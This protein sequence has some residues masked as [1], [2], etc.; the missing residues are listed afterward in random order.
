MRI[1]LLQSVLEALVTWNDGSYDSRYDPIREQPRMTT[2]AKRK[3]R[4]GVEDR[5]TRTLHLSDGTTKTEPSSNH[6]K[7]SRWRARYVDGDGREHEKLFGRKIDAQKWLDNQVSDQVTGTWTDPAKSAITFDAMAERW[8]ATKATRSPK[9]VAGYRSIL[10]TIVLP[11]WRDV[12]LRDVRYD[13]LQV[14][15]TGLS[16]DG[17]VRFEG[18]GLSASRVRQT[19]QLVGA[20]L[21]FAVRAKH[22]SANPAEGM[23]LPRLPETEQQ[24]LTHDQL[25]RVAV[26]SGRLRTLVFVLGYCGLRFGE[27][28]ALQVA[29]IDVAAR[30][31]RVRRSVTYVRK[32]GLVEGP[33]KNHSSR[34]V[35]VPPFIV[36]LL[37]TEIGGRDVSALVF[38]SARGGGYLTLGQARYTFQ[39]ATA[40]VDGCDGVRLH[41][42]RHTCASLAISAG[43]NVKVVQRLLGHKTAVLTLDRYGHLFADDLDAVANAFQAAA[44]EA[45]AGGLRAVVS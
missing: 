37:T 17:S 14:W 27:A 39:K 26:A 9:T 43:A 24:Y 1:G 19:H 42:L 4:A 11:R 45:T 2:N 35:P 31:I 13:D 36:Q 40:V 23:D 44:A 10:D 6:G 7:G 32:T 18:N 15:I 22:L 12:P 41:D 30:R 16:A 38:T 28:A 25:R 5:W 21:K 3:C 34:T 20:V 33:T 29:D 8:I